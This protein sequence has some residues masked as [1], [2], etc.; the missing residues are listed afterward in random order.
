MENPNQRKKT[1][2]KHFSIL[3][4][5]SRIEE[6]HHLIY[7]IFAGTFFAIT[8]LDL[9]LLLSLTL[10][11]NEHVASRLVVGVLIL[12][13]LLLV[14]FFMRK[15]S[16]KI[17]SWMLIFLYS[18]I[19]F[20][21]LALWSI[22][23][24]I[25]ILTLAFVI[26]LSS[27][28]LGT[29]HIIP[30]TL[31]VIGILF[32]VQLLNH[33]G[34]LNPDFT[35][36]STR[37]DF[38]DG[39]SYST[40]FGVYALI[41]W[42]AGSQRRQAMRKMKVAEIAV[43]KERDLLEMRLEEHTKLLRK[44][45]F[46]EMRQ[47]YHFA[48]LGQLTTIVLHELSNNLSVLNLDIDDLKNRHSNLDS[49]ARAQESISYLDS[50]V[51][52]VRRQIKQSHRNTKFNAIKVIKEYVQQYDLKSKSNKIKLELVVSPKVRSLYVYGDPLRLSQILTILVNNSIDAYTRVK[53]PELQTVCI[54]VSIRK[55]LLQIS[56]IDYGPGI[57]EKIRKKLFV[58][59]TSSKQ[60]GLGIGLFIAQQIM[61]T[62]FKGSLHL[63]PE[64]DKT[65]F[66]ITLPLLDINSPKPPKHSPLGP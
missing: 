9:I 17:A 3:L 51:E 43:Q 53:N 4:S 44:S 45:Q 46:E 54:N 56:V 49:I 34:I 16:F 63:S 65:Q 66:V 22:N 36:L 58:P 61:E 26:F 41:A 7:L 48:E 59:K 50:I 6:S 64:V 14:L 32:L 33:L 24:P 1:F 42:I 52:R 39:A 40:I 60:N 19:A 28:L 5:D 11:N 12:S 21:I 10:F 38:G 23:A 13:Y 8:C 57:S 37:S 27:I 31:G 2:F 20:N 35:T 55:K 18:A 62:H 15:R 30:V 47:L 29:N 25:G